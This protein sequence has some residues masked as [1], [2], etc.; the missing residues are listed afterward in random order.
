MICHLLIRYDTLLYLPVTFILGE[1]IVWTRQ[2]WTRIQCSHTCPRVRHCAT[3]C[4]TLV[5]ISFSALCNPL[6]PHVSRSPQS[7]HSFASVLLV[8]LSNP[9]LSQHVLSTRYPDTWPHMFH[10]V[11]LFV[12]HLSELPFRL[13][14]PF[15]RYTCPHRHS[16]CTVSLSTWGS[17][18][19]AR[20]RQACET[21]HVY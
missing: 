4:L 5:Q 3:F 16:R 20:L 12:S 19:S 18:Y 2:V 8:L 17:R 7:L 14:P 10:I 13:C 21:A 9:F 1:F 6:L 11:Q 15:A